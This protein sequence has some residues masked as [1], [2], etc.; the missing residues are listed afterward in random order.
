MQARSLAQ[1]HRLA[2]AADTLEQG[3]RTH[4]DSARLKLQLGSLLVRLGQV[5]RGDRLLEAALMTVP[6]DPAGLKDR[7]HAQLRIGNVKLAEE[8]LRKSLWYQPSDAEAHFRQD[9]D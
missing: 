8:L 2:E 6:S 3:L 4:P 7:A 9:L 5:E 1:S